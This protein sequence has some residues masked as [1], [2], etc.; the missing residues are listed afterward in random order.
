MRSVSLSTLL[1]ICKRMLIF[2]LHN[3]SAN[4]YKTTKHCTILQVQAGQGLT[5]NIAGQMA[6]LGGAQAAALGAMGASQAAGQIGA[7]NALTG[8]FGTG[9]NL[10]MQ[11][12]LMNRYFG[13][14][15]VGP[16]GG[17]AWSDLG[18]AG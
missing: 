4:T 7:A 13:G 1:L 6:N 2:R 16:T 18:P 8:A 10:Y 17:Y 11:N 9:A 14:G 3:N 12:Q 5:S 15:G